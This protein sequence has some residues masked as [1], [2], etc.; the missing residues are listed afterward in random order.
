MDLLKN[1]H[2][3]TDEIRMMSRFI[4]T[5]G[6]I[7]IVSVSAILLRQPSPR[8][9]LPAPLLEN[10]VVSEETA[11][12]DFQDVSLNWG[13][14][15]TH[16]QSS[17]HLTALTETLGAGIC[18]FDFNQDGWMDIFFVGGSGHSRYYG[19]KSWWNKEGGNRLLLNVEGIR[20]ED[21]TEQAGLGKRIWGMGCAI[22]DLNNNGLN[23]LLVT[24]IASNTLYKNKGDG[25]FEDITTGSGINNERWSTGA[26]FGDFNR[27]GLLDIYLSNY[28][29]Y[30]KGARTFEHTSG[31]R[32]TGSVAFNP[33]LYD[34]EPNQLLINKGDFKFVD[35]AKKAGVSNSLGRSLGSRWVDLNQDN[36][37]D[38]IVINDHNSPNQVFINHEGRAFNR[39]KERYAAFEVAGAHDLLIGD[40]NNDGQDNF[41]MSRGMSH[42]PVLLSKKTDTG[43]QQGSAYSDSAWASNLAQARLLP[44]TSWGSAAGDFNNNGRLDIYVANGMIMPDIDSH[45]VAQAQANSLF[46]NHGNGLFKVQ[47]L[48]KS[49]QHPYSSRSA[50]PVD[51]N[52]DGKL[53][54]LVSNNNDLLQIFENQASTTGNWLGLELVSRNNAAGISGTKLELTTDLLSI[55]RPLGTHQ[56]FLSQGDPRTHIGLGKSKLIK[57]MTLRWPDGK[58]T[59]F[60]NIE[61]NLYYRIDQTD[62]SIMPI[63]QRHTSQ[64]N[65]LA[66]SSQ[67]DDGALNAY[68]KVLLQAEPQLVLNQ[69]NQVWREGSDTVKTTILKHIEQHWDISYLPIVQKSLLSTNNILRLIGIDILKHAELESSIAW[70]LPLIEDSDSRIQC[71]SAETFAFF[72]DEEEAVT[73]RKT[74]SISPLIKVLESG[75]ATAR[76]CAANALAAAENKRPILP[77]LKLA[78]STDPVEVRTNAIRALGLIRDTSARASLVALVQSPDTMPEI[79]AASLIALNRLNDPGLE[80]LIESLFHHDDTGASEPARDVRRLKILTFLLNHPDGIVFPKKKLELRLGAL[81]DSIQSQDASPASRNP[82]RIIAALETIEAGKLTSQ[83]AFVEAQLAHQ[84][85]QVQQHA[86]SALLSLNT[87]KA[88]HRFEQAMLDNSFSMF[89]E[90]ITKAK[91]NTTNLSNDFLSRFANSDISEPDSFVKLTAML[92]ALPSNSA[93]RLFNHLLDS[94]LP[95]ITRK[96]L[97]ELCATGNLAIAITNPLTATEIKTDLFSPELHYAYASCYLSKSPVRQGNSADLKKRLALKQF[98]SEPNWSER[99][100]TEL[101]LKLAETD[102]VVTKTMLLSWVSTNKNDRFSAIQTAR[103]MQII[104]QQGFSSSIE[105]LLWATLKDDKQTPQMRLETASLLMEVEPK[106]VL[107]YLDEQLKDD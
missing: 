52:N 71:A 17:K 20:F 86:L 39:G 87:K 80:R 29:R 66:W 84:N 85:I 27:D 96:N 37:L 78:N 73:H 83:L 89:S 18:I 62:H 55:K 16:T 95:K 11:S 41:F 1:R 93:N 69:L 31:F 25:T 6:L 98:M 40:F 13:V 44:F 76:I 4:L 46:I 14:T 90:V 91:N 102:A 82:A 74:L 28:I 9:V 72:F 60:N 35:I 68:S 107:G 101:L 56:G 47:S 92:S 32:T 10:N 50:V 42:P 65:S 58:V 33:I 24:G 103:A 2:I 5:I 8:E 48:E 88:K 7:S 59:T 43:V 64:T 70:L 99:A 67:L 79:V 61:P 30:Q 106:R 15:A 45:F 77:L 38:L 104:M 34:P 63:K 23:D 75:S 26:S 54:V 105:A 97:Y 19:K 21:V 81:T 36:W 3:S 94:N 12:V 51:L 100:K 22:A 57:T 49:R 53:E